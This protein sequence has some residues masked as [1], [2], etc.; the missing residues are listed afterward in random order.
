MFVFSSSKNPQISRR[1]QA[2]LAPGSR[3]LARCRNPMQRS[4]FSSLLDF[5]DF[6]LVTVVKAVATPDSA[7]ELLLTAKN[8]ENVIDEVRPYLIADG[9]N[10]A[11]HEIDGNI[12]RFWIVSSSNSSISYQCNSTVNAISFYGNLKQS[13]KRALYHFAESRMIFKGD[14]C[15]ISR[16]GLVALV[17]ASALMSVA[18]AIETVKS[19]APA[20]GPNR[21][22][23]PFWVLGWSLR[24]VILRLLLAVNYSDC[25][26]IEE[27]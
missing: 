3:S 2:S 18:M 27:G 12:V 26:G 16:T 9:G 6:V 8:V 5:F 17:Q 23:A 7:V 22:L 15:V 24:C 4:S 11:L 10:V 1:I 25:G 19:A 21:S 13:W 14:R 20:P